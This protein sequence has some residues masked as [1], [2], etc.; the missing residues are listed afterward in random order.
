M[1]VMNMQ[2]SMEG[3]K[4]RLE[5]AKREVVDYDRFCGEIFDND[6]NGEGFHVIHDDLG[7][8][9]TV[10]KVSE[11]LIPR[12]IDNRHNGFVIST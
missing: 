5:C 8:I 2:F 7:I 10:S 4:I 12:K 1:K 3:R 11:R 9:K 6:C